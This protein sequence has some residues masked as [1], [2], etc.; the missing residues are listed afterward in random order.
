[1]RKEEK[2]S[3]G[4]L[5]RSKN[6]VLSFFSR[7]PWFGVIASLSSILGLVLTIYFFFL[8]IREPNLTFAVRPGRSEVVNAR[9]ASRLVIK[10]RGHPVSGGITSA[11]VA[12]WNAGGE[13]IEGGEGGDIRRPIVISTSPAVPILSATIKPLSSQIATRFTMNTQRFSQGLLGVEWDVLEKGEGAF[14]D[15]IYN[16]PPDVA[17][18]MGGKIKRQRKITVYQNKIGYTSPLEEYESERRAIH[19]ARLLSPVLAFIAAVGLVIC[20]IRLP[21]QEVGL[22]RKAHIGISVCLVF[23]IAIFLATYWMSADPAPPLS[24]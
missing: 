12:L 24:F 15:L 8:S 7:N 5:I 14:V 22:Q 1:M 16:G 10:Y 18:T 11:R 9:L 23:M 2:R 19:N 13:P 3:A 4:R 6:P 20:L 21:A 17:I